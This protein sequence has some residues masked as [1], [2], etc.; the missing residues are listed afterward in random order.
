MRRAGDE[1]TRRTSGPGQV[2]QD[3][4]M[5][6]GAGAKLVVETEDPAMGRG[7]VKMEDVEQPSFLEKTATLMGG[8]R[9]MIVE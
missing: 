4:A 2:E 3:P 8:G 1:G 9:D 7:A 6:R 5:G